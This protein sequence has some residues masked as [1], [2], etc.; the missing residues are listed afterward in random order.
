MTPS[1]RLRNPGQGKCALGFLAALC[2]LLS[3]SAVARRATEQTA[4][5]TLTEA[6]WSE[7][8]IAKG[9]IWRRHRFEDLFDSKQSINILDVDLNRGDLRISFAWADS[10]TEPVSSMAERA[11]AI[12]AVNG[13]FFDREKGRSLCFLRVNGTTI[14]PGSR[15]T[16][17]VDAGVLTVGPSGETR[18]VPRPEGGWKA[19]EP[20][21]H[22]MAA[23]PLLVHD[24]E[25]ARMAETRF[26]R[27]R[28]PRTAVGLTKDNHLLL[29]VVDGRTSS[30][31]GMS[32]HELTRTMLALGCREALNLDGGGSTTMWIRGKPH[33]GVVNCPSDNGTFDHLGARS[34]ANAVVV[35]RPTPEKEALPASQTRRSR[36]E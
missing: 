19:L 13:T 3:L 10:G 30:A 14:A 20:N 24:G 9:L 12:A 11:G 17:D 7:E 32:C 5:A 36:E 2:V 29:V 35:S 28:H 34:C 31:A 21:L 23:K 27:Q 25:P 18:V 33:E 26:V 16:F 15:G 1:R 4:E 6:R 8:E 22:A